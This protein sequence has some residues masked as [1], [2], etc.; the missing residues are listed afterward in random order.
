MVAVASDPDGDIVSPVEILV[1]AAGAP[2]GVGNLSPYKETLLEARLA[3]HTAPRLTPILCVASLDL[4][5]EAISGK[6]V[7]QNR[8]KVWSEMLYGAT[9][10]SL[11]SILDTDVWAELKQLLGLRDA[12]AH[13]RDHVLRLPPVLQ[14]PERKFIERGHQYEEPLAPSARWSL[15]VSLKTIRNTGRRLVI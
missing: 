3:A 8:P 12:L 11:E 10:V 5:F 14:A 9:G 6:R 15:S 7:R 4:F 13:G 1:R 2:L